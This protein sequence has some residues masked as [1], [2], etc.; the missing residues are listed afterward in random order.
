MENTY[1][2]ASQTTKAI[3][4]AIV[5]VGAEPEALL[6][7]ADL[8]IEQVEF[9]DYDKHIA[10]WQAGEALLNSPDIAL[11]V[12]SKNS[13][14]DRGIVGGVFISSKTLLDAVQAATQFLHILVDYIH[15]E[16]RSDK[17][18]FYVK[19]SY[20]K[21]IFHHY[22]LE[23]IA[24]SFLNWLRIYSN[25]PLRPCHVQFQFPQQYCQSKYKASFG[26]FVEFDQSENL[27]VFP[28]TVM[29]EERMNYSKYINTLL[30]KQATE[31]DQ[32]Q[33][34]N[35]SFIDRA[36]QAIKVC[37]HQR[38][39]SSRDI[40]NQLNVSQRTYHRKLLAEAITHQQLL[41]QVRKEIA[42]SYLPDPN[43]SIKYI[44]YHLGYGDLSS[45]SRAFKR[46]TGYS[47][48]N[49]IKKLKSLSA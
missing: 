40:A 7:T 27:L 38:N 11:L 22:G 32:T 23:H 33:V 49:Y 44:A 42:I 28:S 9:D 20:S 16:L 41:D 30:L 10:L 19:F 31:I 48:S 5:E 2:Y 45:F 24:L 6:K 17:R 3:Y 29:R 25:K 15:V 12:G 35:E 13:P 39:S 4:H 37:T 8:T 21:E 36:V 1:E 26:C 34:K 14:F 18:H 43:S 46:W 47:P